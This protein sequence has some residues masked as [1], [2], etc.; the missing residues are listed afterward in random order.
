MTPTIKADDN[1]LRRILFALI[2][3]AVVTGGVAAYAAVSAD[4]TGVV[5]LSMS[6]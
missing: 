1:F 2:F 4:Q 6:L 5:N 3:C